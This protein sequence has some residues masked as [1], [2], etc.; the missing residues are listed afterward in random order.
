MLVLARYKVS[1]YSFSIASH[2]RTG[3][4]SC[5]PENKIEIEISTAKNLGNI[6]GMLR[7]GYLDENY[8]KNADETHFLINIEKGHPIGFCGDVQVRYSDVVG[9]VEVLTM[10]VMVIGRWVAHT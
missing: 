3:K 8:V 5:S 7:A 9:R 2:A 4:Q 10:L 1:Q 6:C